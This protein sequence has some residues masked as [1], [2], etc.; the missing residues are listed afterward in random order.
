MW[1]H[2]HKIITVTKL[3]SL[4][5]LYNFACFLYKQHP[6]FLLFMKIKKFVE[7][8]PSWSAIFVSIFLFVYCYFLLLLAFSFPSHSLTKQKNW[9]WNKSQREI[10]FVKC[11]FMLLLI[12]R[13]WVREKKENKRNDT[14]DKS[15][16]MKIKFIVWMKNLYKNLLIFNLFADLWKNKQ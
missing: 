5:Q 16:K 2:T 8:L 15:K 11:F 14:S 1:W 6:C 12:E 13:I 10:P 3:F 4:S 9:Q 7:L